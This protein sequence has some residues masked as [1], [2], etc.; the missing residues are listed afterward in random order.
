MVTISDY[1]SFDIPDEHY[2]EQTAALIDDWVDENFSLFLNNNDTDS[3]TDDFLDNA[4]TLVAEFAWHLYCNR[5]EKPGHWTTEGVDLMCCYWMPND[6]VIPPNKVTHLIP[7]LTLFMAWMIKTSRINNQTDVIDGLTM[8]QPELQKRYADKNYWGDIKVMRLKMEERWGDSLPNRPPTDNEMAEIIKT[9]PPKEDFAPKP[10]EPLPS[11]TS[12]ILKQYPTA[13]SVCAALSCYHATVFPDDIVVAGIHHQEAIIPLLLD[14]LDYVA[15]HYATLDDSYM[16]HFYALYLL[17]QFREK[18]AFLKIL[19]ILE[20]PDEGAKKLLGD[21][22]TDYSMSNILAST[23]G[24]DIT[25]LHQFIMD[26][27]TGMFPRGTGINTLLSLYATKQLSFDDLAGRLKLYLY[28]DF[29][30]DKKVQ[31]YLVTTVGH[32][33]LDA[34]VEPLFNDIK[35]LLRS[36]YI[37]HNHFGLAELAD[38]VNKGREHCRLQKSGCYGYITDIKS[39]MGQWW[40]CFQAKSFTDT[41]FNSYAEAAPRK[42]S[43]K[44]GRNE[45]CSCG[46]GKKFKKCCLN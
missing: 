24:G 11:M 21:L 34:Y 37:D 20:L 25:R 26:N 5:L 38:T 18:H 6:W 43:K 30:N 46:S 32:C 33:V 23:Y 15:Q 7:A 42:S 13:G 3:F 40:A 45:P 36:G 29:S 8:V 16:L 4:R 14:S 31:S 2:S 17:A 1:T 28:S 22:C 19:T 39:S 44:L 10:L 35:Q 9:L 27:H 41:E 12:D